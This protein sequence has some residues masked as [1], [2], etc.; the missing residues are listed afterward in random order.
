MYPVSSR[1]QHYQVG[2]Y[3]YSNYNACPPFILV[4]EGW[5]SVEILCSFGDSL[6]GNLSLYTF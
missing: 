1:K 6:V 4:P 3:S 2:N 5:I